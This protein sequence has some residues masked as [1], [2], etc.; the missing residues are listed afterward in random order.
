MTKRHGKNGDFWGCTN[1]PRCR[2]TCDD[3][4]GKP[5]LEGASRRSASRAG[6]TAAPVY[7]APPSDSLMMSDE[8]MAAFTAQYQPEF[9]AQAFLSTT[10]APKVR[11]WGTEPKPSAAPMEHMEKAKEK[12]KT[13][14]KSSTSKSRSTGSKSTARTRSSRG[15]ADIPF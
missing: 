8:E 13:W 15:S 7:N 14:S 12:R 9:S 1:F 2:M 5:D 3:V 4:D 6:Q 11:K 10:A